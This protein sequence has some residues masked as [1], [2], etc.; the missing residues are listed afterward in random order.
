MSLKVCN[1]LSQVC[2]TII[3]IKVGFLCLDSDL[4]NFLNDLF[5]VT[6]EVV[7]LGL[8]FLISFIDDVDKN[9]TVVL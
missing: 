2:R 4:V 7:V 5:Q 6:H 9:F 1:L 8:D 3:G